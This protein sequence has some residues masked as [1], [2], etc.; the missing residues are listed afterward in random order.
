MELQ[1]DKE[2]A[3]LEAVFY[4]ET[5]PLDEASLVRITG[6]SK[7]RAYTDFG[8]LGYQSQKRILGLSQR[9]VWQA[10]RKQTFKGGNGN[11]FHNSLF[12]AYHPQ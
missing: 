10:E 7:E 3:L 4:L 11:P 12:P 8:R 2:T 6:L 1:L 9:T 5:E